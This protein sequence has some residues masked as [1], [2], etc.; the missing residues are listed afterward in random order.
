MSESDYEYCR[1]VYIYSMLKHM[2][3]VR[4][5]METCNKRNKLNVYTIIL[6]YRE[7][8]ELFS[9]KCTAVFIDLVGLSDRTLCSILL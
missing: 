8:Y 2:Y 9:L 6:H 3:Q 4:K 7:N 1:L 5:N